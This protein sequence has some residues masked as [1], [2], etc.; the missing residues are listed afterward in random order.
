G[1]QGGGS[2]L[3]PGGDEVVDRDLEGVGDAVHG[4]AGRG[5]LPVFHAGQ[6]GP[7]SFGSLGQVFEGPSA[8]FAEGPDGVSADGD[9]A[10]AS[11][12]ACCCLS[13][14]TLCRHEVGKIPN[15]DDAN[16]TWSTVVSAMPTPE[17]E[18]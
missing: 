6:V 2:C 4:D 7:R 16:V 18:G 13:M 10:H 12:V 8:L 11:H 14:S 5:A 15:F 9:S 3:L 17:D 1:R